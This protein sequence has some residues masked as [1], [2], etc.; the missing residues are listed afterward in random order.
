MEFMRVVA[1]VVFGVIVYYCALTNMPAALG[2]IGFLVM[3]A[4]GW[5]EVRLDRIGKAMDAN[6]TMM[7]H[8]QRR[9]NGDPFEAD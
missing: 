4:A 3:M 9:S 6:F 7:R 2:I 1:A 8:L 5:N